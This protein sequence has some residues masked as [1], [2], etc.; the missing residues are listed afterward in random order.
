MDKI[1]IEFGVPEH[2]WLNMNFQWRD[3]KLNIDLS[4]VPIDPIK[5]LIH[6]LIQLSKGI[7]TPSQVLWHLEPHCYYFQLKKGV[8]NFEVIISESSSFDSEPI[9]LVKKFEGNYKQII[10]PLYRSLKKF[11]SFS[12]KEP[13]WNELNSDSILKLTELIKINKS[14]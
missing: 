6:T 11:S 12:Y 9:E 14:L 7:N 8:K 2:G 1:K 5:Q 13:H 4:D 10:L 3:F